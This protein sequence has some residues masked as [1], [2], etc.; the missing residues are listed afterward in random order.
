MATLEER[1]KRLWDKWIGK[2][3]IC[4]TNGYQTNPAS[5]S[6]YKCTVEGID[7][8]GNSLF[9]VLLY[10]DG[11]KRMTMSCIF[12]YREDSWN[13][14]VDMEPEA[15]WRLIENIVNRFSATDWRG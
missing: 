2:T 8:I 13:A 11:T 9:P 7:S 14:L 1:K 10:E 5:L 3:V 12:S 4:V 15:R 6:I